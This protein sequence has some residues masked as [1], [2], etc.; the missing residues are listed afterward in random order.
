MCP[1]LNKGARTNLLPAGGF[2]A[3]TVTDA[4]GVFGFGV[5]SIPIKSKMPTMWEELNPFPSTS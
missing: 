5:V 4:S 3:G 2:P 1:P